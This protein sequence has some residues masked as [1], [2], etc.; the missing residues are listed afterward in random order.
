ME[1]GEAQ[2]RFLEADVTH[3]QQW[4]ALSLN[5]QAWFTRAARAKSR[6]VVY[7]EG[8]MWTSRHLVLS[9][10]NP[11]L[12]DE[13]LERALHWFRTQY[14]QEEVTCWYLTAA[15]PGDLAARLLARGFEPDRSPHWM[16]CHLRDLPSQRVPSSAFD[17]QIFDDEPAS[18]GDELSSYPVE[19]SNVRSIMHRLYPRN[20]RSL[21]AF[22][23]SRIVGR[24][25]LN[26]TTGEWGIGGLFAMEVLP[27]ARKQGIGSALT[28]EACNLARQ[29]GCHHLMLNA[30]PMGEHVYRRVG[31][32]SLGT[33]PGWYLRPEFAE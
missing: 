22:Q 12:I 30:T 29:M 23:K 5:N 24:C 18:Q 17:I 25:M 20:V 26:L 33:R 4:Q 14:P 2:E 19:R 9:A 3:E 32:Q 7:E 1:S 13:Q 27:A 31:F 15:A 10:V 28:W 6:E 11:L 8:V 16:W 21:V